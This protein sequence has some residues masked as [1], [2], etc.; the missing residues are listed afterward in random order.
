MSVLFGSDLGDAA[1][2]DGCMDLLEVSQVLLV[3]L[4]ELGVLHPTL[5]FYVTLGEGD[6]HFTT[7]VLQRLVLVLGTGELGVLSP[8]CSVGLEDVGSVVA[9][10]DGLVD[11]DGSS[12]H[13]VEGRGDGSTGSVED[14]HV[15]RSFPSKYVQIHH[16]VST[17]C[18]QGFYS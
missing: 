18:G 6:S 11:G 2:G 14:R 8:R 3:E 17:A 12:G 9:S 5:E 13:D 16:A 4:G 15:S 1:R 10:H 7:P